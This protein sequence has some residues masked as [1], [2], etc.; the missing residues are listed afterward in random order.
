MD[1]RSLRGRLATRSLLTSGVGCLETGA[2]SLSP[3]NRKEVDLAQR[4]PEAKK[5]S[6]HLFV[7]YGQMQ[8]NNANASNVPEQI[9]QQLREEGRQAY[10]KA[11][12]AE[13]KNPEALVA[14]GRLASIAGDEER[15]KQ[16]LTKATL[17]YP[18]SAAVWYEVGMY[19]CKH[20]SAGARH[21]NA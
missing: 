19:H 11:L 3:E 21:W 6:A 13:P 17:Y 20:M 15:A 12:E 14:L 9:Q 2:S 18:Q 5:S 7:A 8:E 10:M 1:N 4:P 16:Y